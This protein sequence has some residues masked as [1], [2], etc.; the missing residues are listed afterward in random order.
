M[1]RGPAWPPLGP[2][3]APQLPHCVPAVAALCPRSVPIVTP[4]P[5]CCPDV[6]SS[7]LRCGPAMNPLWPRR[8]CG[9]AV[10]LLWS[11]PHMARWAPLWHRIC[12]SAIPWWPGRGKEPPRTALPQTS[13]PP[14]G[15]MVGG[16]EWKIRWLAEPSLAP[17]NPAQTLLTRSRPY[18]SPAKPN[19]LR[20][21]QDG[22][23]WRVPLRPG[24]NGR[25]P[26]R[27]PRLGRPLGVAGG[28]ARPAVRG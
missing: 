7:W 2:A 11:L 8:R 28:G 27:V 20:P 10:T 17:P 5:R 9:P 23:R 1:W 4:C 14:A 22:P 15:W 18:A 25:P 19:Y 21:A 24:Q 13:S 3:V 12:P 16:M 6:A 26:R